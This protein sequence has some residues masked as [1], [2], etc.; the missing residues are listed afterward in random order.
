MTDIRTEDIERTAD[1]ET[2][3]AET[4][5][6]TEVALESRSEPVEP[7]IDYEKIIED[8]LAELRSEFHELSDVT[9]IT[10][11]NNPLRYAALRDLGLSPTEAYL[12]TKKRVPADTRAHLD[13][14]YGRRASSPYGSMPQR[15]LTAARELFGDLSDAD[16]Q[17]L[18]RK[19]TK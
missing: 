4:S 14:A 17:R 19:V 10:E 3:I 16:I 6:V 12:A 15:E 8:D 5:E 2:E 7:E 9:S 11:L 18:Y 1:S 13:T